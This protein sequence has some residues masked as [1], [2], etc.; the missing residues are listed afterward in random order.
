MHCYN[1]HRYM[2]AAGTDSALAT[3]L[4]LVCC[5]LCC[6]ATCRVVQLLLL[7]LLPDHVQHTPHN[8]PNGQLC[9]HNIHDSSSSSPHH[10]HC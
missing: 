1:K 10:P 7:L 3:H 8:V 2:G 4:L 9:V 5:I 6:L